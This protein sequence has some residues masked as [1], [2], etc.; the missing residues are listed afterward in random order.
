M[1]HV[2]STGALKKWTVATALKCAMGVMVASKAT[3]AVRELEGAQHGASLAAA[4]AAAAAAAVAVTTRGD[5]ARR[6]WRMPHAARRGSAG[7]SVAQQRALCGG[8]AHAVRSSNGRLGPPASARARALSL[9]VSR[10]LDSSRPPPRSL[11]FRSSRAPGGGR[12]L[13]LSIFRRGSSH[14]DSS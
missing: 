2:I 9:P 7:V 8:R 14:R 10:A 13:F 5:A 3:D 4:A 12:W 11:G 1:R 6:M